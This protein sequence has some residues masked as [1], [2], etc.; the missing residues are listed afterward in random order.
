MSGVNT[1]EFPRPLLLI[2]IVTHPGRTCECYLWKIYTRFHSSGSIIL[3]IF[4]FLIALSP[5]SIFRHSSS[6][7]FLLGVFALYL[8]YSSS[9][10]GSNQKNQLHDHSRTSNSFARDRTNKPT[11]KTNQ[12]RRLK[13]RKQRGLSLYI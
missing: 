12:T 7:V 4:H 11:K 6:L 8:I 2:F 9:R 5:D 13:K 10:F 3:M 1:F